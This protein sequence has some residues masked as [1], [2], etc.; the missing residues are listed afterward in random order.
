MNRISSLLEFFGV[1]IRS[2]LCYVGV[3]IFAVSPTCQIVNQLNSA[4]FSFFSVLMCEQMSEVFSAQLKSMCNFWPRVNFCRLLLPMFI[5]LWR[6][7]W[8]FRSQRLE[9]Q[10]LHID[11][12]PLRK[13]TGCC[14]ILMWKPDEGLLGSLSQYTIWAKAV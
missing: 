6:A 9:P 2:H 3:W 14:I 7:Y 5:S 10:C 13:G 4:S 12:I 8:V 11:G 1:D